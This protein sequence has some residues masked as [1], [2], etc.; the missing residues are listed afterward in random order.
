[1]K[2]ER[3]FSGIFRL[4]YK[5]MKE[6]VEAL[7]AQDLNFERP[8]DRMLFAGSLNRTFKNNIFKINE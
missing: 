2:S 1:M 3:N 6:F 4:F 8:L 5:L 7:L